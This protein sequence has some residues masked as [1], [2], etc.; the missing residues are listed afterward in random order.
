MKAIG[1]TPFEKAVATAYGSRAGLGGTPHH[2][3]GAEG[4]AETVYLGVFRRDRLVAVG[5]FDEEIKRGQD[6]ELNR[7]LRQSGGTVWFTPDLQVEYRPRSSLTRLARQFVATGMWRG[8][9]ARRFPTSNSIRYFIPP[10]AVVGILA[11][12]ILGA[13]GIATGNGPLTAVLIIPGVYVVFVLL[14]AI[15]TARNGVQAFLWYLIV[16]PTIHFGWG[17]GF[18]LGFLKLTRNITARTGR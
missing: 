2:I 4:P 6:W 5:L 11:G 12:L 16:L 18:L 10:L 7:R 9:L 1:V 3:G 17:V 13:V 15:E 8:E 14:A